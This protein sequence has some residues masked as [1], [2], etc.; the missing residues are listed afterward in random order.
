M[1]DEGGVDIVGVSHLG[2]EVLMVTPPTQR[3]LWLSVGTTAGRDFAPGHPGGSAGR[4]VVDPQGLVEPKTTDTQYIAG[5]F[6]TNFTLFMFQEF[7]ENGVL[8]FLELSFL[9][10]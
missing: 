7:L 9:K 1:G 10:I 8:A 6:C 2:I 3:H 4:G 5:F